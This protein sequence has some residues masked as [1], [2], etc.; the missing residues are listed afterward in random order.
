MCVSRVV[1]LVGREFMDVSRERWWKLVDGR[2]RKG[3][4]DGSGEISFVYTCVHVGGRVGE[5]KEV[6]RRWNFM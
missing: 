2:G 4:P 1:G 5:R 3:T 6:S